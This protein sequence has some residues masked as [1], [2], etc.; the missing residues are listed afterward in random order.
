MNNK[1]NYTLVGLFVVLGFF[2][3]SLSVFWLVKPTDEKEMKN[4]LSILMNRFWD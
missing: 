4:I 2:A 1:T 3:L